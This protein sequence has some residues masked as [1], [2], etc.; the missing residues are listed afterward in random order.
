[1][2]LESRIRK[3]LCERAVKNFLDVFILSRLESGKHMGGHDFVRLIHEKFGILMSPATIYST[4]YALERE[5]FVTSY[6]TRK[7]RVYKIADK[8]RQ[9]IKGANHAMNPVQNL[10]ERILKQRRS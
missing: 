4:L 10:I 7:S 9:F 5:G 6:T 1:M 3:Q 2:T 8:G